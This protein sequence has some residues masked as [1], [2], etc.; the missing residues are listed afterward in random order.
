MKRKVFSSGISFG[1]IEG[2]FAGR[3]AFFWAKQKTFGETFRKIVQLPDKPKETTFKF[4]FQEF[5][6]KHG[7]RYFQN[8]EEVFLAKSLS[9][10]PIHIRKWKNFRTKDFTSGVFFGSKVA[11]FLNLS[12]IVRQGLLKFRSK[13]ENDKQCTV[14]KKNQKNPQLLL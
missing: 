12:K 1:L 3:D 6:H 2:S 7:E 8:A 9:F 14:S 4:V 11:L 13:S 5:G 10:F